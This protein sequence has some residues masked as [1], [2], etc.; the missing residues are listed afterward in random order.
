MKFYQCNHCKQIAV[1]ELDR[2][3]KLFC[4]GEAMSE[5]VPNTH[6]GAGEKHVPVVT[7]EGNKVSV[8]VG[9][10]DH[11]MLDVHYIMFIAIETTQGHYVKHLQPGEAP[12]AEF[13]LAEGEE[14][15]K[16]YEYCNLHSLWSN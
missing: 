11:P 5:L 4:C 6:D 8:N 3:V 1:K 13:C 2:G 15:V 7:I 12:H 16:A 9:A 14:F 10:V